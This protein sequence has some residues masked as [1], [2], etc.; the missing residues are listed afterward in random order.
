MSEN[1]DLAAMSEIEAETSAIRAE[2][3]EHYE[4][5]VD[6]ALASNRKIYQWHYDDGRECMFVVARNAVEAW[7]WVGAATYENR[8]TPVVRDHENVVC[9]LERKR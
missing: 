7:A 1:Y 6:E 2:G 5:A 4:R 9:K 8:L 3:F